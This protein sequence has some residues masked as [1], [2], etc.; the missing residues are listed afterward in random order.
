MTEKELIQFIRETRAAILLE[1][2]GGG[3]RIGKQAAPVS[4]YNSG[5]L[6]VL[7]SLTKALQGGKIDAEA[8]RI[9]METGFE[10]LVRGA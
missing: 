10:G 7:I 8:N 9:A 5:A 6:N 4:P 1:P 2:A 3:K